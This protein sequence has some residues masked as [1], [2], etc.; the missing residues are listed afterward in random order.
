MFGHFSCEQQRMKSTVSCTC[1]CRAFNKS[2][3]KRKKSLD[4]H[5]IESFIF[6]KIYKTVWYN[7][8]I[9]KS[10][11][12]SSISWAKFLKCHPTVCNLVLNYSTLIICGR[13]SE[14][15]NQNEYVWTFTY[16]HQYIT[17]TR[18]N[19]MAATDNTS[20]WPL[21]GLL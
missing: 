6:K 3:R 20:N 2:K 9:V 19:L 4:D 18:D 16:Y 10:I 21:F 1:Y 15:I 7:F 11:V 12:T 17:C 8:S 5:R 14:E 13:D